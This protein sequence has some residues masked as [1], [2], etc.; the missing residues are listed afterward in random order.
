M[1]FFGHTFFPGKYSLPT[2]S[3]QDVYGKKFKF[4]TSENPPVTFLI[5]CGDSLTGLVRLLESIEA[6]ST[7]LEVEIIL[8]LEEANGDVAQFIANN[9]QGTSTFILFQP[10]NLLETL[11]RAISGSKGEFYAILRT[12]VFLQP[13]WLN[14]LLSE[15]S[16]NQNIGIV[17]GKVIATDG[18]L[19]EAGTFLDAEYHLQNYGKSDFPKRP[20]YNFIRELECTSGSNHLI[21]K[22]DFE[23]SGGFDVALPTLVKAFCKLT[24]T[25]R[26][27]L[28]KNIIYTPQAVSV[29]YESAA[30][31]EI[32]D[33]SIFLE[34]MGEDLIARSVDDD[35][36]ARSLLHSRTV[37]FI[38]IGLPEYDR[39]SGSLRAFYLLKMFKELGNHVIVVPR[40]GQTAS[41]YLE[42]L[43]S[44]GVEV[45]YKFPDRKGMMKELTA[46]LPS[47]DIAWICRPQLN[48]EFE[49]IFNYNSSIKWIFDTIDLHYVRLA[50]EA[51]LFRNKKLMRK[52]VR[53]KKLE[54]AIASKADL[55]LTVTDDERKLLNGQGVKNV[56]VIPNIH[57]N[58][59]VIEYPEFSQR[60]GLLFIGSYHH[61]P[62]V[63]AVKWLVEDIM[64]IVW[65]KLKI[66]VTLLGNAPSK[67]VKG[68]ETELVKVPGYVKDIE[69]YFTSHRVFVAPLR[70][71]AGM[72][73]KIGQSLAYKLP[74]VT[75][76][77]GAEGVGLTHNVDVLIAEDKK[78]F[79]QQI[80]KVYQDEQLWKEL[81]LNSEKVLNSYSPDQVKDK[82][83]A[84]IEGLLSS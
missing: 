18:L 51:E 38:D 83:E 30:N 45:L 49:W 84:L 6:N 52:S 34:G 5:L 66:P 60:E 16:K 47:V 73:G 17:G 32:L 28:R 19:D 14:R 63:D 11:N 40:K 23:A 22:S 7:G 78:V 41:P 54:L 24:L 44:L 68:L 57:E 35:V 15:I 27:K 36:N 46:L 29:R 50:R 26:L 13:N 70:Y 20:K 21:R 82:L 42:E 74:I 77:I 3:N 62:N 1:R 12:S 8:I 65:E 39:D 10:H 2:L 53:F 25:I 4:S 75:T 61:P 76:A 48:A 33:V 56:A 64:P 9:I 43:V 79:A 72:K 71:G 80:M 67:E 81:A 31:D 55:T 69:P 59:H 37:L 58:H